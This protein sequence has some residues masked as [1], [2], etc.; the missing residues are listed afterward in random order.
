MM[1]AGDYGALV[2]V[3][4]PGRPPGAPP[5]STDVVG[6]GVRIKWYEE[7]SYNWC[8][9]LFRYTRS[10]DVFLCPSAVYNYVHRPGDRHLV[11]SFKTVLWSANP[12][13]KGTPPMSNLGW[14]NNTISEVAVAR[15]QGDGGLKWE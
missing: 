12:S 14:Y 8:E 13:I 2:P 4:V 10:A 1:Y 5:P 3:W 11:T 15:P 9:T 7:N 6:S